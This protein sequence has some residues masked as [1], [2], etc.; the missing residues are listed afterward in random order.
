M[1]RQTENQWLNGMHYGSL[2]ND[3]LKFPNMAPLAESMGFE[4]EVLNSPDLLSEKII[5]VL[6]LE[7]NVI[8]EV[9]LNPLNSVLPIVKAGSVN[10]DMDPEFRYS[11]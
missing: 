1:I 7:K 8:C 2:S 3:Y 10:T 9:F 5:R 11:E 4:Y 6:K